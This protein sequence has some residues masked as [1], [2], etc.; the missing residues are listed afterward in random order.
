MTI[1]DIAPP[2]TR[3]DIEISF[4]SLLLLSKRRSKQIQD[5]RARFTIPLAPFLAA[6]AVAVQGVSPEVYDG[7][8]PGPVL[9]SGVVCC[10][11]AGQCVGESEII[12]GVLVDNSLTMAKEIWFD[13]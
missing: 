4:V 13:I 9:V 5:R 2:E 12:Y 1:P 3:L 10:D 7:N 11:A 8:I 6:K